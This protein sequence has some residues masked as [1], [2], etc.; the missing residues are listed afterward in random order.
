MLAVGTAYTVWKSGLQ[1][2]RVQDVVLIPGMLRF[3]R[4]M[5]SAA[6]YTGQEGT[7]SP[8]AQYWPFAS[9]RVAECY[10]LI[11]MFTWVAG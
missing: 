7:M 9:S 2:L 6:F 11:V 5:F 1:A 8:N 10:W 3:F 4:L